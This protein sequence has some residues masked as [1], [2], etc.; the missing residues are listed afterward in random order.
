MSRIHTNQLI[1]IYGKNF[2]N[3]NVPVAAPCVLRFDSGVGVPPDEKRR[4]NFHKL[5]KQQY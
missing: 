4:P 2:K 1:G 5:T 3:L